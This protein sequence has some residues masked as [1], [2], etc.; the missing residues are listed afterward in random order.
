MKTK[1]QM[2]EAIRKILEER[3]ENLLTEIND[4]AEE[5]QEGDKE[6]EFYEAYA[7]SAEEIL[8][9][10]YDTPDWSETE[11]YDFVKNRIRS[12]LSLDKEIIDSEILFDGTILYH[13]EIK[14][15]A[16]DVHIGDR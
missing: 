11:I 6:K 1:I 9:H 8:G 3:M 5:I 7:D 4:R 14:N 15:G 16:Y 13:Y 2:T 12:I 10:I